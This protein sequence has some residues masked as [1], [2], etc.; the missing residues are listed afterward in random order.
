VKL[1]LNMV[2]PRRRWTRD[3]MLAA[4]AEKFSPGM[5]VTA[6]AR[7]HGTRRSNLFANSCD[8]LSASWAGA[9][10]PCFTCC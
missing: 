5:T 9:T 10:R 1:D 7:A 4:L 2:A 8:A 6:V 3:E